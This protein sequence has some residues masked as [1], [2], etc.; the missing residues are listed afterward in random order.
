MVM[1]TITELSEMLN[2]LL[3]IVEEMNTSLVELENRV[4]FLEATTDDSEE[5][6][7]SDSPHDLEMVSDNEGD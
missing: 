2:N 1:Q 6:D 4:R 5:D 3:I 7:T